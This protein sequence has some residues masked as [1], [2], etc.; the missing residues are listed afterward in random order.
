[1]NDM[2]R[3]ALIAA[4]LSAGTIAAQQP[5]KKNSAII[6][7]ATDSL[8]MRPLSGAEVLISGV[9]RTILTDSLGRFRVDSLPAGNYEVGLFHPLL[10]SLAISLSSP[11]FSLGPDSASLIS[12]AVPSAATLIAQTCKSRMRTL[13]S[14]AIFG[15]LLDPDSGEPVPHA[16]VSIAWVHFDVS[17]VVG[18]KQ[19]P[20]LVRDSTDSH[21]VFRLCG[22]PAELDARLQANYRGVMTADVPISTSAADGDFIIRPLYISRSDT[23][24][25][26]VGRASVT[27]K[28][29]YAGG[30]PAT[31]SHVE[32]LGTKAAAVVDERGE[33]ILSGA[34]S[35]T[36]MLLVRH[37]GWEPRE[38]P[39]D[40]SSSQPRRVAVQL[41]KFVP[42]MDKVVV[43]A[44]AERALE[45][46]GFSS[47]QKS[48]MGHYITAADI[49]RRNARQLSDVFRTIP[50]V[51][52]EQRG[53]ESVI[54]S[55]RAGS[56]NGQD[57]VSYFVDG[58]L[59]QAIGGNASDF[60]NPSEVAGIE[61]YQSSQ[62]PPQFT[63]AN[64]SSCLTIVIWTKHGGR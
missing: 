33:F 12:L 30:Q 48:G 52:V 9:N 14:S 50:G 28:V 58:L 61:V 42:V 11:K 16:E 6:G 1:M 23:A 34:P 35:G 41:K 38:F 55:T 44:R 57:C 4:A 20:R 26:H 3:F 46:A 8:H 7:V 63:S 31:G 32:I 53:F 60:V 27:G 24:G 17:S 2:L 37:L 39:V 25:T 13:G 64:G 19:T 10:D 59:F 15:R 54:T 5:Q 43:T 29:T 51:T 40:L 62:V 45:N 56:L 47:R 21:G 36:Q 18:V 22:L 49:E